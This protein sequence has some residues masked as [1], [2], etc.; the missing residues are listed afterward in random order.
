MEIRIVIS[1]WRYQWT[2]LKDSCISYC[3][4]RKWCPMSFLQVLICWQV[5]CLIKSFKW[6]LKTFLWVDC[7]MHVCVVFSVFFQETYKLIV[8]FQNIMEKHWSQFIYS[9]Y[10]YCRD[11][12]ISFSYAIIPHLPLLKTKDLWLIW[13]KNVRQSNS[14]SSPNMGLVSQVNLYVFSNGYGKGNFNWGKVWLTSP[15]VNSNGNYCM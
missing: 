4:T 7:D 10:V 1:N 15:K 5:I 3:C 11:P 12:S 9:V 13:I 8:K 2:K 6:V 14:F